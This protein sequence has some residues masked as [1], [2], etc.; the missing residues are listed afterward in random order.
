MTQQR[1]QAATDIYNLKYWGAPYFSINQ[2]GH[3]QVCP[4]ARLENSILFSELIK[5]IRQKSLRFPVLLRF[6]DIIQ[7]RICA[8]HNSFLNAAESLYYRA[9]HLAVYPIKVN[10]QYS[11]VNEVLQQPANCVGLEAG[12]K[13]ELMAV[14]AVAEKQRLII[15]NGYKDREYIR[16]ALM[17]KKTG[18]KIII[19]IEKLSELQVVLEQ[20]EILN[21]EPAL[22]VRIRLS[23]MGRGKWQ[24]SGGE[25]S[26]FGLS[27]AQLL[28]LMDQLAVKKSLQYLSLLHFHMGSQV[29]GLDDLQQ[30]LMEAM[31]C[32]IALHKAGSRMSMLDVGGGL[33]IDYDGTHSANMYSMSYSMDEYAQM[34]LGNVKKLCDAENITHPQIITESGRAM[35]AHHAM[36]ITDVIETE[37]RTEETRTDC[38]PHP[39]I[40]K[41]LRVKQ[42]LEA[43]NLAASFK[44]L[45]N[46]R[47][48]AGAA[49][50]EGT[51]DLKQ[52]ASMDASYYAICRQMLKMLAA[53]DDL[54]NELNEILADK[55]F[56]NLSIFQ[57]MP[58]VWG[59]DQVFP[60]MPLQRLNEAADCRA[61]LYDL[62]CDSDGH[63]EYYADEQ[64]IES[65]LPL[66]KLD[67]GEDYYLGIF[68]L[69]A[70]QE[71]L[72]D[73]HN[74]FGDTD[75]V[76]IRLTEHGGYELVDEEWG[77]RAEQ[78]LQYV[79][80]DI[81][82][83]RVCYQQKINQ[84]DL[85]QQEKSQYMEAFE[86]G[87]HGYTYYEKE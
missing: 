65:S 48:K 25:K 87:L 37:S 14:L 56:C 42:T 60:I 78:L 3:L 44:I 28:K 4:D 84:S 22:G 24:N 63:I 9:T 77:D 26:K 80:F 29:S 10:Q 1:I 11:V 49:F 67:P 12:S 83:M 86:A 31:R 19:V 15:C 18:Q 61:V 58:D 36:L 64:T 47:R 69:G 6:N 79:H 27:S 50:I 85:S 66:H 39:L 74:L 33:A 70:Y 13:P 34:I 75:T 43:D 45:N 62:T 41:M 55:Y 59:I 72:G 35:V 21:V 30:G 38:L 76:N 73:M 5:K 81:E 82:K 68:L 54:W 71:I 46:I 40:E 51:M 20:S 2:Q 53:D 23:A 16:L 52:R 7:H 32:Y 8:L 57:S 17:A